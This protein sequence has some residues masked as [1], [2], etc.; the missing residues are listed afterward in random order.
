MTGA[1][2][3]ALQTTLHVAQRQQ[4]RVDLARIDAGS[5]LDQVHGRRTYRIAAPARGR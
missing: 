2:P 1:Q 3:L 4:D 5:E